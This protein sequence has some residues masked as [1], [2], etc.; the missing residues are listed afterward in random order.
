MFDVVVYK[1]KINQG[2]YLNNLDITGVPDAAYQ[3]LVS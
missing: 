3:L 1:A 2:N